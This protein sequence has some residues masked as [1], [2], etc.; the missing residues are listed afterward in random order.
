M[1]SDVGPKTKEKMAAR[2]NFRK[3]NI[4]REGIELTKETY[5]LTNTFPKSETY[6][7]ISQLQRAAVSIPSNI[8][9]GTSRGT[10]KHFKQYLETALG[11]A[12]EWETQILIAFEIEYISEEVY[13]KLEIKIQ[14]IQGMITRFTEG[15][16]S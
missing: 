8:A 5:T 13:K 11:S 2:H 7:L 6:G 15:L 10:D 3:L 14:A 12:F 4:W 16:K 1:Q 9:E